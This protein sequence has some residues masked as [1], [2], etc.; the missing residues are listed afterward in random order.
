MAGYLAAH[1]EA[2]YDHKTLRQAII[3]GS[4]MASFTCE[5]FSTR[6]LESLTKEDLE[7]RI[8]AFRKAT[9]W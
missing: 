8:E 4:M 3:H 5:A 2:P 7:H 1:G 9:L 6:R